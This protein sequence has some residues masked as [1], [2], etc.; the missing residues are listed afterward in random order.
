MDLRFDWY[1]HVFATAK[2]S[3]EENCF[4]R[5]ASAS[6]S[7]RVPCCCTGTSECRSARVLGLARLCDAIGVLLFHLT[8][9]VREATS[10]LLGGD[11]AIVSTLRIGAGVMSDP[12]AVMST[13]R[14][15][16][17]IL[18]QFT[19]RFSGRQARNPPP[20]NCAAPSESLWTSEFP[21]IICAIPVPPSVPEH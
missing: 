1:T 14:G 4:P 3:S 13:L 15:G 5:R 11:G 20:F 10:W 2:H 9:F 12:W 17:W 6:P 7:T 18:D 16:G 8:G 19:T 21:Q